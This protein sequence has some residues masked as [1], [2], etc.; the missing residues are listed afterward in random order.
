MASEQGPNSATQTPCSAADRE[1]LAALSAGAP[2]G[3]DS[4]APAPV[5]STA[6]NAPTTLSS[7]P[8]TIEFELAVEVL[9]HKSRGAWFEGLHRWA[10][11]GAIVFGSAAAAQVV[12]VKLCG[13]LAVLSATID[14]AFNVPERA[15]QNLDIA[16]KY[17]R[18]TED[19]AAKEFSVD[20]CRDARK[21]MLRLS[22]DEPP[23]YQAA[24]GV[25]FNQAI[26]ALGRDK[27]HRATIQWWKRLLRHMWRFDDVEGR[28]SV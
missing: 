11:F 1:G 5:A 27:R 3:A 19:T 20:A 21:A 12:N 23:V 6:V 10:M 17:L 8:A 7:D 4:S 2:S 15:R 25:A 26:T 16:A 24:K 28:S 22:I 18:I 13:M 9:Y 14:L